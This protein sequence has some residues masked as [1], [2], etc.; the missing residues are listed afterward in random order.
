M[1][2][3]AQAGRMLAHVIRERPRRGVFS[4][5]ESDEELIGRLARGN[6]DALDAL[7]ARYARPV[8][9][10]AFRMLGDEGEAEEVTQDVFVRTW[11]HAQSFDRER[12]RFGTWLMSMT[13]H[14]AIDALRKRGRRLS[15]ITGDTA[16]LLMGRATDPRADVM[17]IADE[18]IQEQ[19]VRQALQSL[20]AAQREAIELAYFA[21]LSHLEIAALL[22]NPLGT[23]KARIRR[24]MDRLRQLLVD[25]TGKGV[26]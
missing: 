7:Y 6:L 2:E 11:R 9:S 17:T 23:I 4:V 24:G 13:H 25:A 22:G 3:Y 14:V 18:H 8:Y 20:P 1:P 19:E 26:E 5:Q 12:G 10:L 21:G 15:P 16:S